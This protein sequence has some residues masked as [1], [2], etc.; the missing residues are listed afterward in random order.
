MTQCW[1]QAG[2][3]H[4]YRVAGDFIIDRVEEYELSSYIKSRAL[5]FYDVRDGCLP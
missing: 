2:L 1:F 3:G 4:Q 5:S